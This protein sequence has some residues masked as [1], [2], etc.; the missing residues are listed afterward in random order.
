MP[1]KTDMAYTAYETD[2]P[3]NQGKAEKIKA[4]LPLWQV[5]MKR[6]MCILSHTL[7]TEGK[8]PRWTDTKEWDDRLSQRQWNSVTRQAKGM[9]DSWMGL[10]Q[11]D[12]KRIVSHS[13]LD[14][15]TRH[16]LYKINKRRAW[17]E[18]VDDEDHKLARRIIKHLRKRIPFPDPA[19]CRTMVMDGKIAEIQPSHMGGVYYYWARVSTL[20]KNK[21]LYAPLAIHSNLEQH[22]NPD[23]P[24]NLCNQLQVRVNEDGTLTT[25]LMTARPK[26][27]PRETGSILGLD[28]GMKSLFA[29][30]DGRLYGLSLFAWLKAR[31]N[32]L[33]NLTRE[34]GHARIPYKRSRRYRNLN[35]RIREHVTNEVNRVLNLIA[36]QQVRELVVED[37][38]FRH[39][40]LSKP[41]NRIVTRAGRHA[42]RMKLDRL[43]Q[44][45]GV[46]IIR[47]NPAYTSQ[48]CPR[49]GYTSPKNRPDQAHFHCQCCGHTNNADIV[50]ANNIKARRS[51]PEYWRWIGKQNILDRLRKEH[52]QR[53]P[54]RIH[55]PDHAERSTA[56]PRQRNSQGRLTRGYKKVA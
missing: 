9:M 18:P 39:G 50:A 47:I 10:R 49:C 4:M 15:E 32:E 14:T 55:C 52:A 54:D 28:W 1:A 43:N 45:R 34:L 29:T 30:S 40:G 24:E 27:A 12:F 25:H 3:I 13:K 51:R 35:R 42:V 37:L 48:E 17:W 41:L 44:I 22:L 16:R 36:D 23:D 20:E 11:N 38:D 7:L 33:T 26:A 21:P 46:T 6:T 53:C 19:R 2:M 56:L 8:L 5:G 31:D